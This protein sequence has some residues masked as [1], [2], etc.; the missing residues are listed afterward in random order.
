MHFWGRGFA[1]IWAQR[2]FHPR[3]NS[4]GPGRNPL[5]GGG[6]VV[7]GEVSHKE[8]NLIR[9][10]KQIRGD[11]NR[12]ILIILATLALPREKNIML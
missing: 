10:L 9:P 4:L 11:D 1:H 2:D 3:S 7:G 12:I 6:W 5:L 8:G